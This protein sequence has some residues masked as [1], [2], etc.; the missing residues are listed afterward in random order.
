MARRNYKQNQGDRSNF[1]RQQ[2]NFR[3]MRPGSPDM[4][5]GGSIENLVRQYLNDRMRNDYNRNFTL[6]KEQHGFINSEPSA[7]ASMGLL[8]Q[9]GLHAANQ[10]K[11][12]LETSSSRE[13]EQIHMNIRN[14]ISNDTGL[15]DYW[16]ITSCPGCQCGGCEVMGLGGGCTSSTSCPG[17]FCVSTS[18]NCCSGVMNPGGN[19]QCNGG[20]SCSCLGFYIMDKYQSQ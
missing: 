10:I 19:Y 8:S 7:A 4:I 1:R 2:S 11:N 18:N 12:I 6:T 15:R 5:Q 3:P 16:D 20:G 17:A 14:M 9:Q 13:V